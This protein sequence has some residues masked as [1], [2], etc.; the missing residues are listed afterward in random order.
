[1]LPDLASTRTIE[2]LSAWYFCVYFLRTSYAIICN[3][4]SRVKIRFFPGLGLWVTSIVSIDLPIL[5]FLIFLFPSI[6][7]R[8]LS[9]TNS[10]PSWPLSSISVKPI[11]L[12]N[13]SPP[14]YDLLFSLM[15]FLETIVLG[16]Q[17]QF[18]SLVLKK[19]KPSRLWRKC[20]LSF[21]V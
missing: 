15:K 6:G 17:N 13:A 14:K 9:L 12:E 8:T 11:I 2:P 5:S 21:F 4:L 20:G 7:L 10:I 3:L 19:S 1:M 16:K 18:K